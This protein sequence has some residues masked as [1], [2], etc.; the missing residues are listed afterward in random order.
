MS[1]GA[2]A[3]SEGEDGCRGMS[4]SERGRGRRD[5][6]LRVRV[7]VFGGQSAKVK[8]EVRLDGDRKIGQGTRCTE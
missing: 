1:V 4:R 8:H 5:V 3:V 7:L 6:V 2:V